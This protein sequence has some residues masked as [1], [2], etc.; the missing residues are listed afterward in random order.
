MDDKERPREGFVPSTLMKAA[1]VAAIGVA[2]ASSF[3][4]WRRKNLGSDPVRLVYAVDVAH[5]YDLKRT[6]ARP[7]R[8]LQT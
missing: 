4:A 8:A 2:L 6:P 5:S 7:S 1:A 3:V